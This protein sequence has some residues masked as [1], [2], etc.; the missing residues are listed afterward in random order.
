MV[1]VKDE[2]Y[3]IKTRVAVGKF[4][5]READEAFIEI[6]EPDGRDLM[7]VKTAF[8]DGDAAL[9]GA[10]L[11]ILPR[12]IVEHNLY[13]TEEALHSNAE[14]A[15]IV[16]N[17]AALCLDLFGKFAEQMVFTLAPPSAERSAGLQG[18]SSGAK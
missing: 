2:S 1:I 4:F 11:D 16:N 15:A 18:S 9:M 8:S 3:L 13:K 6:R 12:I 7:R 17:K 14:V 5:G 10:F